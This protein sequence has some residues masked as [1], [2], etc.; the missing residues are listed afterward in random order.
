MSNSIVLEDWLEVLEA[1]YLRTFIADGGGAVKIAVGNK[2]QRQSLTE[3][4]AERCAK[5]GFFFARMDAAEA[6]AHMPQDIFHALAKQI[7]WHLVARYR[8]LALAAEAGY[9]VD[10]IDDAVPVLVTIAE[11]NRV[12]AQ[13]V[14]QELRP[15]VQ[16]RVGNAPLMARDFRTAMFH[17]CLAQCHDGGP[18]RCQAILDWLTGHN[19]R[20]GAVRQ[21]GLGMPI[22]RNT[23][24]YFVESALHWLATMHTG[25]VLLFDNS[26]VTLPRN[27]RD[28]QRYYTKAMTTDHYELLRQFVDDIDRLQG[29][30]LIVATSPEFIDD[31]APRGW[32]I[33]DALRTRVMDDVRDRHHVNPVAALVRLGDSVPAA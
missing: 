8:M 24:R 31:Q 21:F 28:G 17:L 22:N 5:L 1:E 16:D 18:E 9:M 32:H 4:L 14:L 3:P 15:A 25:T 26:R 23:A 30:L 10:N 33:Y 12:T 29:T 19:P 13:T 27:P 20:I 2:V 6:R 7:D 11:Q